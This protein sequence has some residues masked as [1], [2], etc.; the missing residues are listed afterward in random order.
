MLELVAPFLV[1]KNVDFPIQKCYAYFNYFM[2]TYFPKVLE[3]N[4]LFT[5]EYRF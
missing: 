5:Y 3:F 1:L 4:V 2:N